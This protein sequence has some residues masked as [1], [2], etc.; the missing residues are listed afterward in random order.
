LAQPSTPYRIFHEAR[1][2]R[3]LVLVRKSEAV[4]RT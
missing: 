2:R 1:E 3:D 4:G